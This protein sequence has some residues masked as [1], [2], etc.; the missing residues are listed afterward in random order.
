[1]NTRL[2]FWFAS[3]SVCSACGSSSS[4]HA[5]PRDGGPDVELSADAGVCHATTEQRAI[6]GAT[7]VPECSKVSYV[8]NPPSSGNH[9]FPYPAF[10]VYDSALPRGYWVHSLEH[11]SVVITYNCPNGCAEDLARAKDFVKTAPRDPSCIQSGSLAPRIIL[12]PDPLLDT[13]WA[14]SSWGY[15]LRADCFDAQTFGAFYE[16]HVGHTYEDICVSNFDP[17]L[18]SGALNLPAGC[19]DG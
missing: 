12:T 9:Y 13:V 2:A 10:G 11:G 7:H 19:G 6:E 18:P 16:A 1:M 14:A 15:T 17:R 8:S 3:V 5:A 4:G